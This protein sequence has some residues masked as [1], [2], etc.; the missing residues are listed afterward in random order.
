M[1]KSDKEEAID[2]LLTNVVREYYPG[3]QLEAEV[4]FK[5]GKIHG[6]AKHYYESGELEVEVMCKDDDEVWRK[7]DE[8]V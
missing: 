1:M 8:T 4:M 7:D 5:N 6:L 3:G 2:Y